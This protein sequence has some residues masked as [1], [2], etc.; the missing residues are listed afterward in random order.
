MENTL[1]S[2]DQVP[3]DFYVEANGLYMFSEPIP[4]DTIIHRIITFG[5]I[6]DED[7]SL[8]DS[9]GADVIRLYASAVVMR[10]DEQRRAYRLIHGPETIAHGFFPGVLQLE[11][12]VREGDLVGVIIPEGCKNGSDMLLWCPSQ[13]NV[14]VDSDSCL[15]AFFSANVSLENINEMVSLDNVREVQLKLSA[16]VIMSATPGKCVIYC[17]NR[18]M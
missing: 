7:R 17:K 4:R 14:V 3:S 15:S 5:Y 8:I 12:P 1:L 18:S 10:K 9:R 11:W 2:N 6:R 16:E 13:L